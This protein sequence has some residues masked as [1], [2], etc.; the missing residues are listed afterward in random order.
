MTGVVSRT[1]RASAQCPAR[2]RPAGLKVRDGRGSQGSV[3]WTSSPIHAVALI[4]AQWD[5]GSSG[6]AIVTRA[7]GMPFAHVRQTTRV[8]CGLA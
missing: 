8:A 4:L 7:G 1:V 6:E 3:R 2:R 5:S